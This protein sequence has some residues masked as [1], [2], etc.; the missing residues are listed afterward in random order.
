LTGVN[1][2]RLRYPVEVEVADVIFTS[3][4]FEPAKPVI[5]KVLIPYDVLPTDVH[6]ADVGK[7]PGNG[8]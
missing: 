6:E 4:R 1:A 3:A 7:Q 5:L 8:T 2:K